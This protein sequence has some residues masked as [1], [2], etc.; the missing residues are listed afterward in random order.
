MHAQ[1][2]IRQGSFRQI[3]EMLVMGEKNDLRLLC[4]PAHTVKSGSGSFV[5]EMNQDIV[6]N[7]RHGTVVADVFLQPAKP[8]C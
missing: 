2:L 1:Y 3:D 6:H 5:V 7:E 8:E 4:K